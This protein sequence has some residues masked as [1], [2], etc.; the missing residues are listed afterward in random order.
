MPFMNGLKNMLLKILMNYNL[1]QTLRYR[2]DGQ[3]QLQSTHEKKYVK[4]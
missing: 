3:K 1:Q 2:H 4:Y